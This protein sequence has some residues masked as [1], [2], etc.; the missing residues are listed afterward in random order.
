[1]DYAPN[2]D[3]QLQEMLRAIGVGSFESLIST[4][5]AELH[6]RALEVPSG[7]A[8]SEVIALGEELA[9]RNRALTEVVS[10]L[11]A[12][13]YAHL[14]P[15]VVDAL[16]SRGEWLT[17]YTP[18]QAEAS[19]GTLQAIYEFQTMVCELFQMDVANASLYDGASSVAEA[20]LLALRTTE[21]SRILVSEA[22]HPHAR[23]TLATY[24]IGSTATVQEIPT[25]NGVTDLEALGKAL[26]D[27]VACVILQQPNVFGC[28]EPMGQAGELAHRVGGLFIASVY[29][30]SLGLLQPP[31]AYGAD[32]AVAEG[33]CL[34]SP[35]AYGGPGLGL[36]TTTSALLRKVPGRLAGCTVDQAG[37]RAFTLTLQTREQHIRRERATSNICTNEG[38]LALRATIF[39]SLLGPRGMQ[40]LARLNLEKARYARE[41]LREIPWIS[42]AFDQPVFNE[43]TLQFDAAHP[44]EA[45]NRRLAAA[46]FAGGFPL[47][48]WYPAMP[49]GSLW[50]VTELISK[51]SIDR[52][53]EVLKRVG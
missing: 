15:T 44:V 3:A 10:F 46:G 20:A 1:M 43:F 35:P 18:Y 16:A 2:T 53:I 45:V 26:R 37:R 19:Q 12:G 14:I 48:E 34:G 7:L 49:Q 42:P 31:G 23:E 5:P 9:G 28:L 41:R 32:I 22:V 47:A 36:F 21:R 33:R 38:W 11:G 40:E 30:I 50:C 13:C 4:V 51:A 24:L 25:V 8:E 39:L 27:D 17:P 52:L 6:A 29:P